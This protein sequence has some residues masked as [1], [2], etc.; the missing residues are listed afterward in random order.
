MTMLFQGAVNTALAAATS[1][2][3]LY[4]ATAPGRPSCAVAMLPCMPTNRHL[5][6]MRGSRFSASRRFGM[7]P[8]QIRVRVW[9]EAMI[10]SM[11]AATPSAHTWPG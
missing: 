3:T 5:A 8:M 9:R 10:V 7:G 1:R 6:A 11:S 2:T 4:S